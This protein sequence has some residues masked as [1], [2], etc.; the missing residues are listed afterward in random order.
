MIKK[1]CIIFTFVLIALNISKVEAMTQTNEINILNGQEIEE[2][3]RNSSL[4]VFVVESATQERLPNVTVKVEE[5]DTGISGEYTTK[6][7][8][9]AYIDK[10][11][12]GVVK[13][14]VVA[15]PDEY[16]INPMEFI[17]EIKENRDETYAIGLNH[18][19]G[20]LLIKSEAGTTLYI[21]NDKNVLQS[22]H[23]IGEE[24][25]IY[26]SYMN[27]GKYILKKV[28]NIN[29][30]EVNEVT[31]FFVEENSLCEV[32]L[33]TKE[34]EIVPDE[35][36]EPEE[37]EEDKKD[38]EIEDIDK[39]ETGE[40]V[41]DETEAGK[42]GEIE[43]ESKE[44]ETKEET[45]EDDIKEEIPQQEENKDE[46]KI[47]NETE[48]NKEPE[49]KE[50]EEEIVKENEKE[51]AVE[52]E[53]NNDKED[54]KK[55]ESVEEIKTED[56]EEK[57]E[58]NTENKTNLDKENAV[59]ETK[60]KQDTIINKEENSIKSEVEKQEIETKE[61]KK[62]AKMDENLE[63]TEEKEVVLKVTDTNIKKLPRTGE[64]YFLIKIISV[65]L[66]ILITFISVLCIK[67][68]KTDYKNSLL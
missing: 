1:I 61:D 51:E 22:Q 52:V 43:E 67:K 66:I 31:E 29:G 33:I 16:K 34:I 35:N 30:E 26:L 65:D 27:T 14:T 12:A 63:E 25:H 38:E 55:E 11:G 62:I 57:K 64:D 3:N 21:Y 13:I 20:Q 44:E 41:K 59:E 58:V 2:D 19:T 68:K 36:N 9:I 5:I 24:K 48:E 8:G 50:E 7:D 60:E 53:E 28:S 40:E 47:N 17:I 6:E 39:T 45:N 56:K 49:N 37:N 4:R 54:T 15:V 46:D 10:I 18:K 32:D 23:G 42:T